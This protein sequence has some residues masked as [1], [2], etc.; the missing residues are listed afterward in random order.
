MQGGSDRNGVDDEIFVVRNRHDPVALLVVARRPD[1][2]HK[3][4]LISNN[5][6]GSL[7]TM[8]FMCESGLGQR[9]C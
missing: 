4:R 7:I 5:K 2:K 1:L 6:V 9:L 3:S 8:F